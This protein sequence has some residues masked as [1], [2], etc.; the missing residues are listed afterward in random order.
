[1]SKASPTLI[2]GFV[3]GAIALAVFGS[4]VLGGARWLDR[5]DIFVTY[6]PGS[7]KGLRVGAP[8]DFRGVN[9]GE[10]TD[11][12]VVFNPKDV[13]ARIPVVIQFDPSRIDVPGMPLAASSKEVSRLVEAGFRAQLQFQS[14]LTG[15]LLVN[16]DFRPN[17]PVRLIGGAQPYPEIPTIPSGL[18]QYQESADQVAQQLPNV[19]NR[20]NRLLASVD[21]ELRSTSGDLKRMVANLAAITSGI[22]EQGPV[23]AT[24]VNDAKDST[25]KIR[26]TATV[27]DRTLQTN[28]DAIGALIKE[29]TATA[30][31]VRRMADQID[32]AVADNRGSLRDFTQT[33]LY[34]YTG[35]ALD[36]QRM[37]NEITHLVD[38]LKRDPARLLFGDRVQGV[39]P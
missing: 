34:E 25:G 12:R 13:T 3:I 17:T 15:L 28:Q 35:L 1:M 6:F 29:W 36:A 11:I 22:R 27:L 33:G 26:E 39:G 19:I 2:G 16:L 18:E 10:V 14:L 20:L 37:V 21:D 7:V 24:I 38:E 32:A 8:V 31:S 23:L 30:G 9:I 5:S 4:L